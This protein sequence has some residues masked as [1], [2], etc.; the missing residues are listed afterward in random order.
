MKALNLKKFGTF[1]IIDVPVP[2][3][4]KDELLIRVRAVGICGSDLHGSDGTSGRRIPPVIMGH[5]ASGIVIKSGSSCHRFGPD[6]RVTFDSTIYC[7]E[8]WYCRRGEIN[9]C[10]DRKVLGVSCGEYRRDG[11][12]AEYVVIPERGCYSLPDEVSFPQGALVEPLSI[13]AH[14]LR[15]SPRELGDTA[16]VIG[17]GVIGLLILQLLRISGI[18]TI[19]VSDI[20]EDRLNIAEHTGASVIVNPKKESIEESVAACTG[21]R[22]ADIAFDAVGTD[23]SFQSAI[24]NVRK[25]GTVTLIGNL[26]SVASFPLQ[27]VV[28][29]QIRIQ[30]TNA[31]AGEYPT[32]IEL[33]RQGAINTSA[34]IS[35]VVPLKEGPLWFKRLLNRE[36][37][38]M[39][40]ILEP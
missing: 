1:E 19:I 17:A 18:F 20:A 8:C 21:G 9:F 27:K 2:K 16:V 10:E 37:G 25:G 31:S 4:Q 26:A 34:I 12:F 13:A 30:G 7:G 29:R 38:I 22:G 39:R 23:D 11:A 33:L 28:T 36:K 5:E 6:D 40:V 24:A 32:C 35:K 3:P 15:I 14:A